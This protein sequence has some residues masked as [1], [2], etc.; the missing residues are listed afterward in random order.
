MSGGGKRAS[1]AAPCPAATRTP[2]EFG[3]R[4]CALIPRFGFAAA[5]EFPL[6][7]QRAVGQR[8]TG[9][10][11]T[12]PPAAL[13]RTL[14]AVPLPRS[15]RVRRTLLPHRRARANYLALGHAA[16]NGQSSKHFPAPGPAPSAHGP[17]RASPPGPPLRDLPRVC[18]RGPRF[19]PRTRRTAGLTRSRAAALPSATSRCARAPSRAR[20]ACLWTSTCFAPWTA[21]DTTCRHRAR[22][23]R[24]A[25]RFAP[26]SA[27]NARFPA[28]FGRHRGPFPFSGRCAAV[29]RLRRATGG[30]QGDGPTFAVEVRHLRPAFPVRGLPRPPLQPQARRRAAA[31]ARGGDGGRGRAAARRRTDALAPIQRNA[32][33]LADF[34]DVFDCRGARERD[35]TPARCQQDST[36]KLRHACEVSGG[37]RRGVRRALL[38]RSAPACINRPSF[39]AVFRPRLRSWRANC[40]VR[41]LPARLLPEP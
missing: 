4:E 38:T 17:G 39:T 27:P 30:A 3:R 37:R 7:A 40:T 10:D 33:C 32:V 35:L 28:Q 24:I 19:L 15:L 23:G 8:C 20:C 16:E 31:G 22:C 9:A 25:T 21:S 36:R 2:L 1:A 26:R 34:C 41:S 29:T 18:L 5:P 12:P 6:S 11:A 14:F 13:K